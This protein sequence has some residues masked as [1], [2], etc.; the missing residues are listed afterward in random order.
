VAESTTSTA[1]TATTTTTA[2][3]E[4]TTTTVDPMV[5]AQ[6]AYFVIS[7]QSN[8]EVQGIDYQFGDQIPWSEMPAYCQARA[9]ADERFI[10]AIR[11]YTWPA[12]AQPQVDRVIATNAAEAGH[13]YQC[14]RSDGTAQ[15]IAPLEDT[16]RG[17]TDASS[18]AA[19]EL[20]VAL[21]LPIGR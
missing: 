8:T 13:L 10:A 3:P 11:G 6:S 21:G 12:S 4:T 5:A 15:A 14:A 9:E 17:A 20:R 7:A 19:S 1:S 16:I 2:V 18:G